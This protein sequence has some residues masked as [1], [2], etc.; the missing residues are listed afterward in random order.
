M[1]AIQAEIANVSSFVSDTISS[2]KSLDILHV[3]SPARFLVF[4]FNIYYILCQ[5]LIIWVFSPVSRSF[6][7]VARDVNELDYIETSEISQ[8]T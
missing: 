3:F 6:I 8:S 1:S 4:L 7:V 2:A 5:K